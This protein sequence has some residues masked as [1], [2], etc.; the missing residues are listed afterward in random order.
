M[1]VVNG[2]E[3]K[4]RCSVFPSRYLQGPGALARLEAELRRLGN[5]VFCL[6]DPAVAGVIGPR[7]DAMGGLQMSQRIA[8]GGCTFASIAATVSAAEGAEVLVAFGGGKVVDT[9]RAAADD[10]NI[11]F[12]CVPTVAASDA[13]CSALAVVYDEH[14]RVLQDRFV[15]RNPALVLVDTEVLVQ[16]P[17]R[18]FIS[19]IGDAL[20]TWYEAQACRRSGA[21]NLCGGTGTALAHQAARLC[22]DTLLHHGVQA[23]SDCRQQLLTP[24]FEETVEAC[25]LLSG[26]GFESGGVAA[27]HAIH[28]GL[29]DVDSTHQ[30]L[31]GEKV[32]VGLLASMFLALQDHTQR[33]QLFEF[34]R[35]TGLPVT[36]AQIGVDAANLGQLQQVARRACRA[37]E[38]IHNEPYPVTEAGVVAA[39]RA[40]D[41]FG[42]ATLARGTASSTTTR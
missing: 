3:V 11:A 34:C 38:I 5:R 8:D 32:A 42:R 41:G 17:V 19:G 23:V 20:A 21:G 28:H 16:A 40:M 31:H 2:G 33:V 37:G 35:D 15:R 18:F 10:L 9:G 1:P 12:V 24:D 7:L 29:A 6:V 4:L 26:L 13:P 22:L 14:G 30:A 39:L 25:V 36:L 27:A